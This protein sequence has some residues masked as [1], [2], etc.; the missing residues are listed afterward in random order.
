MLV[1]VNRVIVSLILIVVALL[2]LAV[3][4]TP[5]GVASLLAN[6]L[7]Q[8]NVE[9]VS[10]DHVLIAVAGLA[11]AILCVLGLRVQW[12]R[13][14]P[15][16]IRLAGPGSS[17]LA[18]ESIVDALKRDVTAI[19]DVKSASPIIHGRGNQVDTDIEVRTE[20][21]VDV[22]SKAQEIEQVVRDSVMRHGVKLG[23]VR[24][25]IVVGRGSA[26]PPA[27]SSG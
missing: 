3:A 23:R 13:P 14:R 5:T 21:G 18:T 27:V 4:V 22:P 19:P 16:S 6:A 1:F 17:E 2:A 11:I 25:K 8:V 15:H 7:Q 24:V 20:P 26:T 10:V 12:L 9:P